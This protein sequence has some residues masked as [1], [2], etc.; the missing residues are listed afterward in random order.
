MMKKNLPLIGALLLPSIIIIIHL[1]QNNLNF[2]YDPARDLLAAWDNLSKPTLIGPTS[3]I[4]GV[5]YGP[6]WI[7]LLSLGLFFSKNPLLVTFVTATIPYLII[8]PLFWFRS[9]KLFDKTSL[10]IGWLLFMLSTGMTY[11]TELWNPYPAPLLTIVL[12][13]FI[14]VSH[15]ETISRKSIITMFL[16]GFF[17]GLVINFHLSFGI[18]LLLGIILFYFFD[19]IIALIATKA[20]QKHETFKTRLVYLVTIVS[21]LFVAF[22]PTLLFEARHGFHQMQTLLATFTKFGAVV[23]V[24]GLGKDAIFTEFL[25]SMGKL[26]HVPTFVAGA[27]FLVLL[28]LI[29]YKF[30]KNQTKN[31]QL[32]RVLLLSLSVLLGTALIYFTAKNPIWTYHFIGVE[33]PCLFFIIYIATKF[34]V[35]RKILVIW[36]GVV[37]IL[38]L[39]SFWNTIHHKQT[40]FSQ[41]QEIVKT[42]AS[43]ANNADYT[44]YAYSPSIYI[45]EYSYLFRWLV[46]KN[47]PYDPGAIKQSSGIVYLILPPKKDAL[48]MDFVHFRTPEAY[49]KNVKI[50]HTS[51]GVTIAKNEAIQNK[52]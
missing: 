43:D 8:L 41:Q 31:Y 26:L 24:K 30:Y 3:G 42:I 22:I 7:W 19:S 45:Y 49:Y 6:Y 33:I 51:G 47:V 14:L 23:A 13:F 48:I 16:A 20:K 27:V 32:D 29:F 15:L 46:N 11:A 17:L 1:Y 9:T 52:K 18:A 40:Y 5:F 39:N 38:S 34:S 50:W 35:L 37:V 2:W 10:I 4:P 21:G 36:T 25:N 28:G 12:F 44:V